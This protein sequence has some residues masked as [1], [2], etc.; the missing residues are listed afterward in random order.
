MGKE[1]AREKE[2]KSGRERWVECIQRIGK[3]G[4]YAGW[5]WRRGGKDP[6]ITS[7]LL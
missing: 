7:Q 1:K 6:C 4:M 2:G 5:M 3:I